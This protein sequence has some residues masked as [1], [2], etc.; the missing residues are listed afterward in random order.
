MK[1]RDVEI[2][3]VTR[4]VQALNKLPGIGPKSAQRMAMNILKSPPGY[5]DELA[6]CIINVAKNT[7]YCSKCRNISSSDPCGICTD[8]K[9]DAS[10]VCV[11][12][13]TVDLT[14]IEKTGVFRGLYHVLHGTLNPMDGVGPEEIKAE[15]F[16]SRVKDGGIKEVVIATNPDAL[17]E[18]TAHYLAKLLK[19][20]KIKI[21][22]IARGVPMGGDLQYVDEATL[23][24]SLS[25]RSEFE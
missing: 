15:A 20:L 17:G 23:A 18:A 19:P 5:A 7:H 24:A 6:S 13:E 21:T 16:I 22:R 12:E 1:F 25:A 3:P 9:R 2:D 10:V 11:V 14:V 4:L 8:S